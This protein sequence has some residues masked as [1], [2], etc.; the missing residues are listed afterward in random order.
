MLTFHEIKA[1]AWEQELNITRARVP[2][3]WLVILA[4]TVGK[5][6]SMTFVPDEKH[7]WDGASLPDRT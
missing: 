6:P 7:H 2:G 1:T 3:G 4:A 5:R